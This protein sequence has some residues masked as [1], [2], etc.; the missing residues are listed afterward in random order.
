MAFRKKRR[1]MLLY[2][3]TKRVYFNLEDDLPDSR[4]Q[5]RRFQPPTA[6][7]HSLFR[8]TCMHLS[9]WTQAYLKSMSGKVKREKCP[10]CVLRVARQFTCVFS[11]LHHGLHRFGVG[12]CHEPEKLGPPAAFVEVHLDGLFFLLEHLTFA[13][14]KA[15]N[16]HQHSCNNGTHTK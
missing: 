3:V 10:F 7:F 1:G 6:R 12:Q 2:A 4:G 16:K 9:C 13:I 15:I 8:R 14:V 5:S 11:E